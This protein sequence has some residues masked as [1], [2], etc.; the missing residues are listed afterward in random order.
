[1]LANNV[2][3]PSDVRFKHYVATY[4]NALETLLNLRGVTYEYDRDAFPAMNFNGGRQ[5]GFIAQEVEKILP[6]LV[7]TDSS[8]YKSVNYTNVVPVLVEAVKAQQKQMEQLKAGQ[9]SAEATTK[10][11]SALESEN[12]ELKA[13]LLDMAQ[14]MQR[15]ESETRR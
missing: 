3:V 10:R 12:R 14:R 5:V 7:R 2:S 13:L 1:V 11:L 6:E 15:L 9:K 4:P 8:G